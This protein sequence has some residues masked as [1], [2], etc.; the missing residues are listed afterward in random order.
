[1]KHLSE[2]DIEKMAC[3]DFVPDATSVRRVVRAELRLGELVP[4]PRAPHPKHAVIDLHKKTEDQAWNEIMELA[5]SGV[6]DATIITGASGILKI[7]FQQWARDSLLS[8]YIVSVVPLN[9]GRFAV[10][11]KKIKC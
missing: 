7:K 9:N 6:R 8:P 11:F 10:K 4:K 5:T 3:A 1:M 2:S